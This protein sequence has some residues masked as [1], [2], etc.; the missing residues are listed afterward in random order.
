MPAKAALFDAR[1]NQVFDFGNSPKNFVRY[2]PK[3]RLILMAGFGNLAGNI[4]IWDRKALKRL[5]LFKEDAAVYCEFL[6][7]GLHILTATLSPRLRVD[8]RFRIRNYHGETIWQQDFKELFQIMQVP[9]SASNS[10]EFALNLTEQPPSVVISG[11]SKTQVKPTSAYV[12][13]HLRKKMGSSSSLE[14]KTKSTSGAATSNSNVN[15]APARNSSTNPIV[16]DLE[17]KASGLGRKIRAIEQLKEKMNSGVQLEKNQLDKL[18][19]E[20]SLRQEFDEITA[21]LATLKTQ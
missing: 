16:A 19:A 6:P 21:K 15:A 1:A 5:A 4:E 18:S 20:A 7:D 2:S 3:G 8:N 11:D 12:P 17:K 9:S 14:Q 10:D 13:P